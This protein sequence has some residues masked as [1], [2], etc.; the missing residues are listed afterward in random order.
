SSLPSSA[1]HEVNFFSLASQVERRLGHFEASIRDGESAVELDP[2]NASLAASLAQTYYGLRRFR[3]SERV[4]NATIARL[5]GAKSTGLLIV[6]SGTAVGMGNLE[7]AHAA[8]DSIH[9]NHDADYQAERLRLYL[10]ERDYSGA[11]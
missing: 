2:Q 8:L 1:P 3:D 4:A 11:K 7:E 10:I 9:D 6:K 5:G